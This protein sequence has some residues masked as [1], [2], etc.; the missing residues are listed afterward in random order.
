LIL[1]I[2]DKPSFLAEKI[3]LVLPAYEFTC[4]VLYVYIELEQENILVKQKTLHNR[5]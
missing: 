3:I 4:Q 2:R 5:I 1:H